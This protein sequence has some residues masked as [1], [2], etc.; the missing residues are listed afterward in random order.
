MLRVRSWSNTQCFLISWSFHLAN[1]TLQGGE[2]FLPAVLCA[3]IRCLLIGAEA[4]L[5]HANVGTTFGGSQG[6]EHSPLQAGSG[7]ANAP[8]VGEL[9]QGL[10]DE[11]LAIDDAIPVRHG[12]GAELELATARCRE[13]VVRHPGREERAFGGRAP[14]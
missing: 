13:V 6:P 7:F 4:G 2:E 10:D 1:D 8:A 9:F 14:Q 5:L 11:H 12:V 3:A